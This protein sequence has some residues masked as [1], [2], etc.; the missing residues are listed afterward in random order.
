[1]RKRNEGKLWTKNY[2]L[3]FI[4]SL[5]S[6]FGYSMVMT[7]IPVYAV[8]LGASLSISGLLSG[9]VA[10]SAM[11]L[12]PFSGRITD[13]IN[14][15]H[16]MI[17]ATLING[18]VMIGYAYSTNITM[19]FFLRI[20]HGA[21]I[22][23]NSTASLSLVSRQISKE[24]LG[25][26]LSVYGISFIGAM[27]IGPSVG[28]T[29]SNE[30]GEVVC[31][32][33]AGAFLILSL[34]CMNFFQY[35]SSDIP[36]KKKNTG[37]LSIHNFI[38]KECGIYALI[39]GCLSM[40]DGIIGA[41]LVLYSNSMGYHGI[42]LYFALNSA[43]AIITKTFLSHLVDGLKLR[44]I[45]VPTAVLGSFVAISI[46][47]SKSIVMILV[48]GMVYALAQ[49]LGQ[50]AIQ[51]ACLKSV[52]EERRGVATSTCFL[53]SDAGIGLGS[54]IAGLI[55]QNFGYHVMF[56]AASLPF[57]LAGILIFIQS[58]SAR[59]SAQMNE[60]ECINNN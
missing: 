29:I 37:N 59:V 51:M 13:R 20:V 53:G 32:W 35:N 11:I 50:P 15:K 8:K 31:F 45:I 56:Y 9:L 22:A 24:R 26:G 6:T 55:S 38:A 28:L 43:V 30:L 33:I 17:I 47:A 60:Q 36:E 52:R 1:M 54:I 3:L 49:G 14:N 25:E 27:A 40:F 4:M 44:K 12:R 39:G 41:Y 7:I 19:L 5:L 48:A 18:L 34:L 10:L 2:I 42:G 23:I 57:I 16:V 21:L 58:G 46:G